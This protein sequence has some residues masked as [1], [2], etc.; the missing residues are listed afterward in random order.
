MERAS[1]VVWL[2][3]LVLKLSLELHAIAT[4]WSALVRQRSPRNAVNTMLHARTESLQ[5]RRG[6]SL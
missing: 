4:V 6:E 1:V 5:S 2:V 3:T